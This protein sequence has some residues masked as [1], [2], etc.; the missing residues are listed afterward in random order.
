M[1]PTPSQLGLRLDDDEHCGSVA[2]TDHSYTHV[3]MH[4]DEDTD[5]SVLSMQGFEY[6][7]LF[8]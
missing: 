3:D 8:A 5:V 4:I 6:L 2:I 7:P 1:C